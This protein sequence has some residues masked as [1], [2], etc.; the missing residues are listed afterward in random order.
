M[1]NIRV[2]FSLVGALGLSLFLWSEPFSD[3][4]IRENISGFSAQT[5]GQNA[6]LIWELV[7]MQIPRFGLDPMN[8]NL[9]L[10]PS[11]A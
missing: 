9:H 1:V 11:L 10:N 6:S 5:S 2:N 7:E 3:V 4:W 8:Q